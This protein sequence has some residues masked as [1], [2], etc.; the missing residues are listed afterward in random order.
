[1]QMMQMRQVVLF[2]YLQLLKQYLAGTEVAI[3]KQSQLAYITSSTSLYVIDIKNPYKPVLLNNIG[4][5]TYNFVNSSGASG[6]STVDLGNVRA[7]VE[8]DG[9][10]YV[11][12]QQ[13]GIED[14][15]ISGM[16][17]RIVDINGD[18]IELMV[19][20]DG[21]DPSSDGFIRIKMENAGTY[22]N[23]TD[24]KGTVSAR[25]IEGIN[26]T[27]VEVPSDIT[28]QAKYDLTFTPAS[29]TVCIAKIKTATGVK[30][31]FIVSN[32]AL[33]KITNPDDAAII[34]GGIRQSTKI[35][36]DVQIGGGNSLSPANATT[37]RAEV[38]LQG[39]QTIVLA[40]D[41]LRQDVLYS[42]PTKPDATGCGGV[43][44]YIPLTSLEGLHQ[45]LTSD[46]NGP[47]YVALPDVTAIFPS[48]TLASWASIF[49]GKLPG[50]SLD[51]NGNI[52]AGSEGTGITGN[53]F[54]AR[55][56][57]M[58]VPK[59]FNAQSGMVTFSSGSFKGFD[60]YSKN[61]ID[62]LANKFITTDTPP[63]TDESFFVPYRYQWDKVITPTEINLTPQ[64]NEYVL[65]SDTIFQTV[66]SMT[67]LQKAFTNK[68]GDPVVVAYNHYA[69]GARWLTWG[70]VGFGSSGGKLLDDLSWERLESYLG[71]SLYDGKYLTPK[72]MFPLGQKRNNVPFSA[73]TV[74]Y[75]AGLDHEAHVNGM[76]GYKDYFKNTTDA[77]IKK[78]VTWLKKYGEFNNKIFIIVADH[79]ETAMPEN[80][81]YKKELTSLD[82]NDNEQTIYS[83]QL[84]EMSDTFILDFQVDPKNPDKGKNNKKAELANNNLH[85]WELGNL[86]GQV[87][88]LQ[89]A[90]IRVNYKVLVPNEIDAVFKDK[91]DIPDTGRPTTDKDNADVIA[92]LNGPMAHIYSMI[93]TD[94]KTITEMACRAKPA[95]HRNIC[96]R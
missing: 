39:T 79:G 30:A 75:L 67:A 63:M 47:K 61:I 25:T 58:G 40:I 32:M 3:D 17:P 15:N 37:K 60:A 55:N 38:N 49:T 20:S 56:L 35:I 74:W 46:A 51:E 12:N 24:M 19:Y 50:K 59:K 36:V 92:A 72:L 80:L 14:L 21:T 23:D 22:C 8:K 34:Y 33:D 16:I 4:N 95:G 77:Q 96:E 86:F 81:R 76:G 43:S 68:G 62:A 6:S 66:S 41:G 54:F 28:Y 42:N 1:M 7:L 2:C 9:W 26:E 27:V 11:A 53:E 31:K 93:G 10:V 48:V 73:L 94:Q 70:D 69:K 82:E 18:D 84:A 44:C 57:A 71:N 29:D 88:S 65:K 87:A 64:N 85:I 52:I 83:D 45:I 90:S 78:L 5:E 89:G 13:T 91:D